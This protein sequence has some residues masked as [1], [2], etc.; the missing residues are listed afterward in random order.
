MCIGA[1]IG[2]L[3]VIHIFADIANIEPRKLQAIEHRLRADG[4]EDTAEMFNKVPVES[5][6]TVDIDPRLAADLQNSREFL[7][8]SVWLGGMHKHA[9]APDEIDRSVG[10]RYC[11]KARLPALEVGK[12]E[13][14]EVSRHAFEVSI[15]DIQRGDV[16]RSIF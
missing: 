7:Q 1:K 3:P 14:S 5:T 4:C 2:Y 12:P 15:A 16:S 13:I 6:R 8:A 11:L 9:V 10:N